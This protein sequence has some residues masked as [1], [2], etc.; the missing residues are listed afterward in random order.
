MFGPVPV[1][2]VCGLRECRGSEEHRRDWAVEAV[3]G[4]HVVAGCLLTQCPAISVTWFVV[5]NFGT[6]LVSAKGHLTDPGPSRLAIQ[7]HIQNMLSADICWRQTAS[8]I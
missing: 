7:N 8:G 2:R 4:E 1:E 5:H 6:A 3:L